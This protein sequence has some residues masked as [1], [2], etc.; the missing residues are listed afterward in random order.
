MLGAAFVLAFFTAGGSDLTA[1]DSTVKDKVG[2][3]LDLSKVEVK[4]PKVS[5]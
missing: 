5:Y 3:E 2:S 1:I 4:V